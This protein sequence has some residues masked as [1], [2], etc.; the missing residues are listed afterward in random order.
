[1]CYFFYLVFVG[2]NVEATKDAV[3]FKRKQ[4]EEVEQENQEMASVVECV[5]LEDE[6]YGAFFS[7]FKLFKF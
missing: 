4:D 1:M 6:L 2:S 5:D 7:N 3:F